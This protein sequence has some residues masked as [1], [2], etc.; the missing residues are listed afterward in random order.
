VQIKVNL[1]GDLKKLIF[2]QATANTCGL[3]FTKGVPIS[4][5]LAP[6]EVKILD[7]IYSAACIKLFQMPLVWKNG[8]ISLRPNYGR[9]LNS[10]ICV[11]VLV[12]ITLSLKK[13][14]KSIGTKDI[15]GSILQIFFLARY[16]SQLVFRWNIWIFRIELA[17]LTNLSLEINSLWGICCI[18]YVLMCACSIL[19]IILD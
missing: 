16:F 18:L 5:M 7:W 3:R 10:M 14:S 19:H 12:C 17:E 6:I 8:R 15:D 4:N 2:L 9:I 1:I 11:I 13:L